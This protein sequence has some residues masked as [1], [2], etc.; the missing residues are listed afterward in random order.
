[1]G[2]RREAAPWSFDAAEYCIVI[3]LAIAWQYFRGDFFARY[4]C[5]DVSR[6]PSETA[7]LF[8]YCFLIA[9]VL[10]ALLFP[11]FHERLDRL[12]DRPGSAAL[13][14]SASLSPVLMLLAN[15]VGASVAA[16]LGCLSLVMLALYVSVTII[17]WG[18]RLAAF[19]P[20]RIATLV[21][22]AFV[23]SSVLSYYMFLPQPIVVALLVALPVISAVLYRRLLAYGSTTFGTGRPDSLHQA[24]ATHSDLAFPVL[25]ALFCI[26]AFSVRGLV[27][28]LE[29]AA[30]TSEF[31]LVNALNIAIGIVLLLIAPKA[32]EAEEAARAAAVL[33]AAQAQ[34]EAEEAERA[35]QAAQEEAEEQESGEGEDSGE[36]GEEAESQDAEGEEAEEGQAEEAEEQESEPESE[37]AYEGGSDTVSRAYACLGAPYVWGAVGP[38][39]YDCSGL[40]SY[41]L[42][43]V[44]ERLGTT[45]TFMEWPAVSDPQPGDVCVNWG[46]TGIYIGNNQMIHAATYGVGVIVGPVQAGMIIVRYPG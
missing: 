32:R 26:A 33:A 13:F 18:R 6:A 9:L 10:L 35:A 12:L 36:E 11:A 4:L 14:L 22:C 42:T 44:H 25:L 41:C 19:E 29:A 30:A 7:T 16:P 1:M 31:A 39:G 23:L 34:A 5:F 3:G 2:E 21:T 43:G 20:G 27:A 24:A 37:P 28:P 46:H 38:G 15:A 45:Y 8:Y 40:V 17:A